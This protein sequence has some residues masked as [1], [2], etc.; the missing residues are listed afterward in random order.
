MTWLLVLESVYLFALL[1]IINYSPGLM[2]LTM[3]RNAFPSRQLL[4][5]SST[6]MPNLLVTC[7]LHHWSKAF[8]APNFHL[9]CTEPG[10]WDLGVPRPSSPTIGEP[11]RCPS[12]AKTRVFSSIWSG[13]KI[14]DNVNITPFIE[15]IVVGWKRHA[16]AGEWMN[17]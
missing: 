4:P 7:C 10:L 16:A 11:K 12:L 1:R 17:E 5:K 8:L 3:P 2:L 14:Q 15:H 6:S 9:S 13:N